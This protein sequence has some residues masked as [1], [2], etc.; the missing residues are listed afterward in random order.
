MPAGWS[1]C[2]T[3]SPAT[4]TARA[5]RCSRVP[6]PAR[7][8]PTGSRA[9]GAAS[10]RAAGR[11]ESA[12]FPRSFG[13]LP[14]A[15]LAE[16]IETPGEGQVR[17]MLTVAGNPVISTPDSER[18]DRAFDSLDFMVS[19][20]V[21]V[22]ETTRHADV[23]LPGPSPLRRSHYDVALY[24]LA[25]RNVANYSPPVLEPDPAVPDEWRT[26]LRLTGILTGQG[27][28]ADVDAI[29]DFVAGG[30]RAARARH[31]G[32]AARR[33][34]RGRDRRPAGGALRAGAAARPAAARRALRRPLRRGARRPQPRAA[35]VRAPRRRPRPARAARL[36]EMLRTPSGKVE[37][38]PEPIV[39]DI[40]RLEA[41]L[42]RERQRPHGAD[43][44]APAPL[45]QLLDAQRPPPRQRAAPLHR[46][47]APRRRLPARPRQT[48]R[49]PAS[50]PRRARSRSRSRS[51][52]R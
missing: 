29:D 26:I 39:A 45:Q 5:A 15:A 17:A 4:S 47:R 25:V 43:R 28:D 52:T 30:G 41:A 38:A 42:G 12:A 49:A 18:L 13:E 34:R 11:A 40:P 44:P 46:A 2:S 22:N 48:A 14:V 8:A 9:A 3:C 21:Y 32:V 24:Q 19:L 33:A 7:P 50:A 51:P 16:E 20:D 35:R 31:A 37:L 27:P 23:I 6:P 1:T 36:P 10:C